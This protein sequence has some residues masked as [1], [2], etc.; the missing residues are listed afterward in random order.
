MQERRKQTTP[1]AEYLD[2]LPKSLRDFP[3]FFTPEEKEFL[4]GSP[5]LNQI[6]EK[7]E[8]I[9]IDYDLICKEVPAFEQFPLKEYSEVRMM[10]ASRIFGITVDNVKTD[11]FVPYADMLNHRRPRQTTWYYDQEKEG[12][13]IEACDDIARGEQ[14][15]D[16]YGKKCNSRFFL[17]YG[18]INLNNDANEVPM[19]IYL[20]KND[21]AFDVKL[22][23]INETKPWTKFRV[24]ENLDERVMTEF[25]SWVRFTEFDGD[26]AQL[27]LAKN[28]AINEH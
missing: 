11:G 7:L 3:I 28:E 10:V 9:K 23:L 17:N 21:Q 19:L 27:Y 14:V 5:F 12:F 6:N 26:M 20:N 16:S 2:I 15:Y 13:V 1:F 4:K 18:F 24:V 22:K 8:D 25:I